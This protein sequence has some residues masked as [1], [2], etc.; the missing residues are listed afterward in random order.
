M[1]YFNIQ[2]IC[3]FLLRVWFWWLS[4]RIALSKS[5]AVFKFL[6]VWVFCFCSQR[7]LRSAS[8]YIVDRFRL[9]LRKRRHRNSFFSCTGSPS[10]LFF[11]NR[12][13][14]SECRNAFE[15]QRQIT[16]SL[17]IG[18]IPF[19]ALFWVSFSYMKQRFCYCWRLE[20]AD[21]SFSQVSF[22]ARFGCF[23][24]LLKCGSLFFAFILSLK[25]PNV[26]DLL[27]VFRSIFQL[28]GKLLSILHKRCS[29]NRI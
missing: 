17:Y 18:I 22:S 28:F 20:N 13:P 16:S 5:F 25:R 27:H 15:D 4:W 1:F 3:C 19:A 7:I 23:L 21:T 29:L 2:L 12:F 24:V 26:N 9:P 14:G 8:Y 11:M 6:F 10:L